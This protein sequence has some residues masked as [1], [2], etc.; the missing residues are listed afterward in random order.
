MDTGKETSALEEI[1]SEL[2]NGLRA[3]PVPVRELLWWFGARRRGVLV[4]QE[5]R[6]ALQALGLVTSPDFED[7]HIDAHIAILPEHES[8]SLPK[9]MPGKESTVPAAVAE[10]TAALVDPTFRLSRLPS[11]NRKVTAVNPT[12]TVKHATTIMLTH[13]FSQLPVMTTERDL[14]GVVSWRSI[15]QAQ[16]LGNA[17][18]SVGD[19]MELAR[20]MPWSE[21]VFNALP[22]I[23]EHDYVLVRAHDRTIAGIVT[24]S[25]LS[26]Q[27]RQLAEPFLLLGEIESHLR[28]LLEGAVMETELAA[29]AFPVSTVAPKRVSELTFS[30]YHS[31]LKQVSVWGRLG[32][33]I[34]QEIFCEQLDAVRLIRNDVMH[35]NPDPFDE[36]QLATLRNFAGLVRKIA[37]T[38]SGRSI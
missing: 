12:A 26:I 38:R 23:V 31:L 4:V 2:R 13:G 18:Q 11:A 5:I 37:E 28:N 25:D 9:A 35:F 32:I 20:E 21:S 19:C 30:Q 16:A 6:A 14:K 33:G 8:T 10:L 24:A 17:P 36:S 29:L 15:G 3:R 27:F 7:V 1:A 22:T 34:D